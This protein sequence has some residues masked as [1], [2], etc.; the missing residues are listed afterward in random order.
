[1]SLV[2]MKILAGVAI[3]GSA[4]AQV[5]PPP[6]GGTQPT[7]RTGEPQM[8]RRMR[9]PSP[10]PG[11]VGDTAQV[12]IDLSRIIPVV[13]VRIGGRP[14]RFIVDTGTSGHG[15]VTAAL[16]RT[17]GLQPVGQV[18]AGDPS[19]R[20]QTRSLYRVA[21]LEIGA[22]RLQGL[23]LGETSLPSARFAGIDGILGLGA[24]ENHLLTIDY[25]KASL[26][27]SRASLPA[28]AT[29]YRLTPQG[30]IGVPILVGGETIE[31]HI[32][33]GNAIG[34]LVVPSALA[35]RLPKIGASRSAG[36]AS[37]PISTVDIMEADTDL[38][39]RIG[40]ITLPIARITWPSLGADANV[41]SRAFASSALRID[42][43]N[44]RL[45]IT[46]SG[47]ARRR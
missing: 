22:I 6:P 47:P 28:S 17:L 11:F 3:A 44:R 35:D 31:A 21:E 12:P 19:G 2:A 26:L 33:T 24:F 40:S 7:I 34:A 13:E 15:R 10:P 41:G 32:D 42:H 30:V 8:V 14:Y 25:P 46:P 5:P 27:L 36:K 18:L 4:F 20:T 9:A 38:T 39:V 16:A 45:D 1:M 23:N 43:R 37:T 29:A